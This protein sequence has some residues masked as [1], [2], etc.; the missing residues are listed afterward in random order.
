MGARPKDRQPKK[1]GSVGPWLV[2]QR[3]GCQHAALRFSTLLNSDFWQ[4]SV[5][6]NIRLMVHSQ[7]LLKQSTC[8][9]LPY[10]ESCGPSVFPHLACR[11][12][13]PTSGPCW[14][15]SSSVSALQSIFCP[16]SSVTSLARS[17]TVRGASCKGLALSK[18]VASPGFRSWLVLTLFW[19]RTVQLGHAESFLRAQLGRRGGVWE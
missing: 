19:R 15:R 4:V 6:M 18:T 14:Q 3:A 17:Q 2:L 16:V 13:P 5:E 11:Q 8:L 7:C 9:Q 10:G 12:V 1:L